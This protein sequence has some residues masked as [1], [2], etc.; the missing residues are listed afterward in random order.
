MGI[1]DG[2]APA[3]DGAGCR[4]LLRLVS[5]I[6][7]HGLRAGRQRLDAAGEA[8]HAKGGEIASIGRVLSAF[9]WRAKAAAASRSAAGRVGA[10]CSI[11]MSGSVVMQN[12]KRV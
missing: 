7:R 5:Q 2:S 3:G 9:S 10:G 11:T 12:S 8:E 6:G 4:S 1:P